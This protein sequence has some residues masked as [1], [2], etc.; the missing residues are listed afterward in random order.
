LRAGQL[1]AGHGAHDQSVALANRVLRVDPWSEAA[2]GLIVEAALARGDR[3]GARRSL[4]QCNAMLA[5]L[6]AEP[7][8]ATRLLARRVRAG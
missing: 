8:D 4:E 5:E 6:D 3:L 2:H 7:S 1:L